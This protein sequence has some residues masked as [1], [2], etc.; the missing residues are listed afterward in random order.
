[1]P[2]TLNPI[3][4]SDMKCSHAP[5]IILEPPIPSN[6]DEATV[7]AGLEGLGMSVDTVTR[8]AI[9]ILNLKNICGI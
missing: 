3:F 9:G 1:M 6:A 7:K 2:S 8:E 5:L 4:S